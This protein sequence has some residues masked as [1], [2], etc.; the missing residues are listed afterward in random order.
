MP[1]LMLD[2]ARDGR[3]AR[4]PTPRLVRPAP[5][6]GGSLVVAIVLA[7]STRAA[8]GQDAG[9]DAASADVTAS[10]DAPDAAA[11][12]PAP[13]KTGG[14][15]DAAPSTAGPAAPPSRLP[16]PRNETIVTA[17]ALPAAAPREDR[18]AAA[19]VLSPRESPRAADDLGTLLLEVPG[20]TVTRTGGLGAFSTVSLRGSNPDEVRIFVDGVPLNQAV[21]GAVDLS[22]LPLGD[23]ERIEVYRG[24]APLAFGESALGGVVSI[25]T[26][27]PGATRTTARVGGG[28]FRTMYA[29][30]SAG[31]ALGPLRLY[32]GLHALSA[33]NDFPID[34]PDVPGGYQPGS[35]ENDDLSQLDGVARAVLPLP[36]RRELGAGFIG[37]THDQGLAPLDVYRATAARARSTRLLA[38]L[39]YGSRD[40][41]GAGGRLRASLFGSALWDDFS[42]PLHEIVGVPTDTRDRT[43]TAG[44]RVTAEKPLGERARLAAVA[45][46]RAE[47]FLPRNL[48]D[49]R[50]PT[51]YAATRETAV[52]GLELDL[53]VPRAG[54]DVLPSARLEVARDVR[55]GRDDFGANLPPAPA[56]TRALPILRLGLLRALGDDAALRGNVGY[57]AR[58]PSFLELYGYNRGVLGN[59]TLAPERAINAD[60]GIAARRAGPHGELSASATAFAAHVA[61][62]IAW[63]VFGS[64]MRAE[65]VA[66]ARVLGL[67][68]ELRARGR[69]LGAVAQATLLDAR[70]EGPIAAD[71]DHQ[72]PHHPRAHGYGRLEWRQ[73]FARG[74]GAGGLVGAA[75]AD[76]D[77][78]AGDYWT[79]SGP[80]PARALVGL[81][82]ALERPASGLRLAAS[83]LDVGDSRVQDVPGYPLPG[84]SFLVTL[85]WSRVTEVAPPPAGALA[86]NR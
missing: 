32:A 86:S 83:L 2:A 78:T 43:R 37:L 25:T 6:R 52:A 61:D 53:R 73:P 10:A 38:H 58:I 30:A 69:R 34:T 67:E 19:T 84:R 13:V 48:L 5:R 50:M 35:R 15:D 54:L 21:G 26:R 60:L 33:R 31:G 45:E 62:L 12:M 16:P 17:R 85:E 76:L 63:E 72:L 1:E 49:T 64:Q 46:G 7:L 80:L 82:A 65:N 23:V 59:P 8:Q 57:Y 70:D 55:A 20:A 14:P 18:T 27:T 3:A 68:L 71:H 4:D 75:Y 22:T 41:L 56:E 51:G 39:D 74:A 44:A 47:D 11:S 77:A 9:A 36:G 79:S 29:D 40:D 28:S 42:D 81:G 24:S 66:S